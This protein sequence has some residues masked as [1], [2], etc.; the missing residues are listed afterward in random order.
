[1]E[2]IGRLPIALA[3]LA[4]FALPVI[5]SSR[6]G[7]SWVVPAAAAAGYFGLWY[8]N[9]LLVQRLWFS[10]S[11][12]NTEASI[13]PFLEARVMEAVVALADAFAARLKGDQPRVTVP[14]GEL[15]GL[16]PIARFPARIACALLP[17]NA[18]IGAL[19]R[20]GKGMLSIE[21]GI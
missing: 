5:A 11:L 15:E 7:W 1:L 12:F 21:P 13:E 9:Y 10:A 6:R 8:A 17:W 2:R 16:L 4:V 3:V 19:E 14:L 18:L 20:G